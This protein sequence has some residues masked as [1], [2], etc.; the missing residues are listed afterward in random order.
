MP[1][2]IEIK[3][4]YDRPLKKDGFRILVDRIWP[5]GIKTEVI[6]IDEWAKDIA[7]SPALRKWFGHDPK[8]WNEFQRKY[9]SE[10]K[11]NKGVDVF[12]DRHKDKKLVTLIYAAKDEHHN[13]A[14]VLQ[15]YLQERYAD[16]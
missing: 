4:A 7:P 13:H 12:V 1:P 3:R 14:L 6:E 2:L 8:F 5:R 15:K 16:S 11:K 10:L 9:K